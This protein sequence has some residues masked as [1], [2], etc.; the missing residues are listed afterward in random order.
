MD[1][2]KEAISTK[3]ESKEQEKS[4]GLGEPEDKPSYQRVADQIDKDNEADE[5]V[6]E[7]EKDLSE[8][9]LEALANMSD[10]DIEKALDSTEEGEKDETSESS[11]E[12]VS[13]PEEE[14]TDDEIDE[15]L[16]KRAQK[17]IDKVIAKEKA[18][19]EKNTLLEA[20]INELEA[21]VKTLTK[22]E[23]EEDK[24]LTDEELTKVIN[25]GL[26]ENDASVIVDAINYVADKVKKQTLKEQDEIQQKTRTRAKELQEEWESLV[27]EYSPETYQLDTLKND[28]DFNIG[29][30]TSKLFRLADRI[31]K[32]NNYT[33][34]EKGQTRAAREAY[35]ILLERKIVDRKESPEPKKKDETEGLKNRLKK[36]QRKTRILSGT[37]TAGETKQEDVTEDTELDSYLKER[38]RSKDIAFGFED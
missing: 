38:Q 26:E 7:L 10:E 12:K 21:T 8:D 37:D 13:T 17:R 35:S 33:A 30:K 24:P 36:E 34:L 20:K 14:K 28:P 3:E 11:K 19:T 2:P 25:K 22:G 1:E 29:N 32:Q 15:L 18:A 27:V 23:K 31:Y 16:S 5:I 9:E 6:G 4:E